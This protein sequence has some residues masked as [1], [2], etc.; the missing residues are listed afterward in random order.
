MTEANFQLLTNSRLVNKKW[1]FF[2]KSGKS[3]ERVGQRIFDIVTCR[4][5][6]NTT[7]VELFTWEISKI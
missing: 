7:R 1:K 4:K 3:L 5:Q 6:Q 2:N